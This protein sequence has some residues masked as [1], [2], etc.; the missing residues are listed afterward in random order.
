[1]VELAYA[2][3]GWRI[4]PVLMPVAGYFF[5]L[6]LLN[7]RRHPQLLSA[8]ADFALMIAA[9]SPLFVL[10]L[11]QY[12]GPSP[13]SLAAAGAVLAVVIGLLA[14][15][16]PG[17][18]IYNLPHDQ[19]RD[20]VARTLRRMGLEVLDT[21]AGLRLADRDVAFQIGGFPLLRNVSLRLH[22]ADKAFARQFQ[23]ALARTLAGTEAETTPMTMTMLLLATALMVAPL[24]M[25]ARR[26]PEIVRL[27]T[28][29]LP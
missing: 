24:T 2:D 23:Q 8:K 16:G 26:V 27:L 20:A 6:G 14:P 12:L 11:V 18:V 10:P 25:V 5:F 29:L 21:G 9:L 22:G 4:V 3:P 19:P 17:W 13:A 1:M 15:R 7:S 28:D